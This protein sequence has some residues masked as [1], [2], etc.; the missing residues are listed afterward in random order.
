MPAKV[1]EIVLRPDIG[2]AQKLGPEPCKPGLDLAF[3]GA[4]LAVGAAIAWTVHG[5]R[6]SARADQAGAYAGVTV[7]F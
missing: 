3:A 7:H 6:V 4:V 2:D 1:E 5:V